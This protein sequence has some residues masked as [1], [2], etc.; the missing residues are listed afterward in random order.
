MSEATLKRPAVISASLVEVLSEFLAF[1]HLFRGASIALMRWE[2][3]YPLV[4]KVD[5]TYDH[6]RGEIE[7]FL[8]FVE[9]GAGTTL[10]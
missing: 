8:R 3:L 9:E 2:K 6:A 1:H 7:A 10:S 5:Q 4:T